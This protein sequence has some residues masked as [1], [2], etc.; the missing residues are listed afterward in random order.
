MLTAAS[1]YGRLQDLCPRSILREEFW[2]AVPLHALRR[3]L[4]LT[5]VQALQGV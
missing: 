4:A 5:T 1:M 2:S 3:F